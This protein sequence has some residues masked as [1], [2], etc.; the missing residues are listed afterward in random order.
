MSLSLET[1][2]FLLAQVKNKSATDILTT[3]ST[4]L[5]IRVK[6]TPGMLSQDFGICRRKISL[7]IH[8]D[9]V[10]AAA[11]TKAAELLASF[12]G[13]CAQLTSNDPSFGDDNNDAFI[14]LDI[15]I[16]F[17]DSKSEITNEHARELLNALI[18]PD[19]LPSEADEDNISQISDLI[20]RTAQDNLSRLSG[21][22]R[23]KEKQGSLNGVAENNVYHSLN[24]L[25]KQ[26]KKSRQLLIQQKQQLDNPTMDGFIETT[27]L[28]AIKKSIKAQRG[29]I[30]PSPVRTT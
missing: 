28:P 29:I 4:E 23:E 26:L 15:F 22:L 13:A 18:Y 3:L 25:E 11:R 8:P 10:D 9:K 14:T 1:I 6:Y 17:Y 16:T 12:N 19:E 30:Y 20:W 24:S 5:K 2:D 21:I 7:L 27:V